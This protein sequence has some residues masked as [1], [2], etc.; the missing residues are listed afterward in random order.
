MQCPVCKSHQEQSEIEV[1]A[2]GFDEELFRC[3]LCGSTWSV[4]H[5][6]VDIVKDTQRRSFLA[7]NAE[8][9]EGG[10]NL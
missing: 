2:N 6:L 5:G 3:E 7:A 1:H 9:V 10:D 4:N 8:S